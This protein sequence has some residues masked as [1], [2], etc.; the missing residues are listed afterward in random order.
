[1]YCPVIDTYSPTFREVVFS[2]TKLVGRL[3][4]ELVIS[5]RAKA[6]EYS[7]LWGARSTAEG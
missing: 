4:P 7:V 2:E 6:I 5:N 1:M 3:L